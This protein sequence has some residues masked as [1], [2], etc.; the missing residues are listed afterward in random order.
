MST[1]R[2]TAG[3]RKVRLF[4]SMVVA[5]VVVS[6][7]SYYG[8]SDQIAVTGTVVDFR[9]GES[10]TIANDQVVT[11]QLDVDRRTRYEAEDSRGPSDSSVV[12]IGR[13]ATIWYRST[14]ERR[15]VVERVRVLTDGTS[16]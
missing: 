15:R 2:S 8:S 6:I 14:D 9:V 1:V 5:V 13:P 12:S 4:A 3:A 10:I 7:W 16:R 11:L